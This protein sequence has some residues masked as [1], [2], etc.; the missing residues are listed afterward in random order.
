M[1][2]EVDKIQE[3]I[4]SS[5]DKETQACFV[6]DIPNKSDGQEVSLAGIVEGKNIIRKLNIATIR[7]RDITGSITV[8]MDIDTFTQNQTSFHVKNRIKFNGVVSDEKDK[9][10]NIRRVIKN[11]KD[12]EVVFSLNEAFPGNEYRIG[13]KES[14]LLL[15]RIINIASRELQKSHFFEFESKLLS[16]YSKDDGLESLHVVYPGFG[17]PAALIT[18]PAPQVIEFLL[19][20]FLDRAFTVSTSFASSYRFPN[21]G[22]ETKVIVAK[23]FNLSFDEYKRLIYQISKAIFNHLGKNIE[24]IEPHEING[25]KWENNDATTYVL[26]GKLN[27][28]LYDA[29]IP[30]HQKN[31]HTKVEAIHHIVDDKEILLIEGARESLNNIMISTI[32]IYPTQFLSALKKNP[33]RRIRDLWRIGDEK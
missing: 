33:M 5:F 17:A 23:A 32:V 30:V 9:N 11:I 1:E 7:L 13:E 8:K 26:E 3:Y 29:N 10:D 24:N 18:S 15:S 27:C 28:I 20:S 25:G 19:T 6:I 31:W 12:I 16:T 4:K 2:R 14:L 21:F 22:A